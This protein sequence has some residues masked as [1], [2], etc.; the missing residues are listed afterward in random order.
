MSG[1]DSGRAPF[2]HRHAEY[3]DYDND[4]VYVPLAHL[5]KIRLRPGYTT[6]L[7]RVR[8]DGFWPATASPI[9]TGLVLWEARCGDFANG[10]QIIIDQFISSA[11]SKWAPG[12][13]VLLLSH[14]QEG[15]GPEH[16]RRL[17]GSSALRGKQ[18]AGGPAAAPGAIHPPLRRQMRG[19]PDR[20]GLRKPLV[21]MTPKSLLRHPKVVSTVADL[22][23]GV[24][25]PVLDDRTVRE[26]SSI[27]KILVC[28]GKVY[29]ELLAAREVRKATDP[30][31]AGIAIVRIEQLYPFPEAEFAQELM[32]YPA[33]SAVVWAQEEP[34]NMGAWGFVR[35]HRPARSAAP[36]DRARRRPETPATPL[37]QTPRPEASSSTEA[38]LRAAH[39]R[40]PLPQASGAETQAR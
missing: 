38:G 6:A 29:Y 4:R 12:G 17:S 34:R 7:E 9:R 1:R 14:N 18:H 26:P 33:A 16:F 36:R 35:S 23:E 32:R 37:S 21:V 20:R 11:E 30:T 13:L 40:A 5:A 3:H 27:R 28:S 8:R 39:C 15:S 24:F 19:G 22:T 31:A 2:S 10:A 25:L